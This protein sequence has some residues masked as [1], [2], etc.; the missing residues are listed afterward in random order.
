MNHRYGINHRATEA[1]KP[2]SP[3]DRL[4]FKL[5]V[6]PRVK[7]LE[8]IENGAGVHLFGAGDLFES[9]RP[10]MRETQREHVV[11]PLSRVGV[12]IDGASMERRCAAGGLRQRAMKL[13]LENVR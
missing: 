12:L 3:A 7:R 8:V 1:Q 11:Q 13:E 4:A 9:F 6:Q 2:I 5:L 10:R